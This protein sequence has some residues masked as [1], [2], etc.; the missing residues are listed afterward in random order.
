MPLRRAPTSP[1]DFEQG[2]VSVTVRLPDSA[3]VAADTRF[4]KKLTAIPA[5]PC[6]RENFL[7]T[8]RTVF[9][10]PSSTALVLDGQ[11][12]RIDGLLAR[13]AFQAGNDA[14]I[15]PLVALDREAAFL[16]SIR[17]CEPDEVLL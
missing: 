10:K 3:E 12:I 6:G 11:G 9:D 7:S 1:N 13:H 17:P 5:L 15:I 8:V 16:I 4:A 2:V 14:A